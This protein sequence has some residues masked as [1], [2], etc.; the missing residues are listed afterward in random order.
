MTHQIHLAS[1]KALWVKYKAR[2]LHIDLRYPPEHPTT[3]PMADFFTTTSVVDKA[4]A[5]AITQHG[6]Q[7]AK[8]VVSG[9]AAGHMNETKESGKG[10]NFSMCEIIM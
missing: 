9:V 2:L 10:S 6:E 1:H 8:A 7:D 5:L 4:V 3:S